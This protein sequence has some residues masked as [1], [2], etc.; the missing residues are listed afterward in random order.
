MGV[1]IVEI[2]LL[3]AC[4]VLRAV[5]GPQWVKVPTVIKGVHFN[6]HKEKMSSKPAN[7]ILTN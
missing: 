5:L 1:V 7:V 6:E 3:N 4:E 2:Q